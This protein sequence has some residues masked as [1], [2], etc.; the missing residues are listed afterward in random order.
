MY[1]RLCECDR[2]SVAVQF[3]HFFMA[4]YV[5]NY[6]MLSREHSTVVKHQNLVNALKASNSA[7]AIERIQSHLDQ[8]LQVTLQS[9]DDE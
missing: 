2:C 8:T 9:L 7:E 3:I 1:G 4:H 5:K 6:R